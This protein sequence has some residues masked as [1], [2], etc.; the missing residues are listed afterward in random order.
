MAEKLLH[1]KLTEK[2]IQSFYAVNVSF[3]DSISTDTYGKALSIEFEF[4][5]LKFIKNYSVE[6]KYR[7]KPVGQLS[8]DFL[9]EDKVMVKIVEVPKIDSQIQEQ[10]MFLLRKS[11]YEVCIVLNLAGDRE[12]KRFV[13]TNNFKK[14]K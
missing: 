13:F 12:F 7:D 2:I 10:V 5:G 9:V 4:V 11:R 3:R 6:L 8:V 14:E 1:S